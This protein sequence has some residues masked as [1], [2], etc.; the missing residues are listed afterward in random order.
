[1]TERRPQP[2]I[3]Y[4][5]IAA[6]L[7]TFAVELANGASP[8]TPS[9]AE[10][11]ALGGN[12][13]PLTL[14]GEWWRLGSSLFL[15]FG[16]L[17][18]ALNMICLYQVRTVELMF[19]RAGFAV[20]YAVSGLAG[21]IASLLVNPGNVVAA[22]AS[23][24]VFGVFGAYGAKLLLHRAQFDPEAWTKT[25][26]RLAQFLVLNAVVGLTVPGISISSHIGGLI[27][28][29]AA[30]AALLAGQR[31]EASRLARLVG[32]AVLGIV[33]TGVGVMAIDAPVDVMPVLRK[34]DALEQTRIATMT[35]AAEKLKSGALTRDQYLALV[36]REV[37][38][39]YR[40]LQQEMRALPEVPDRL[41]QL[42]ALT[43][44]L[45]TEHLALWEAFKAL[46]AETDPAKREALGEAHHRAAETVK[47]RLELLDA[48]IRRL[49]P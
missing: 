11:I 22:G 31:A 37:Y 16:V 24:C 14:H 12:Y 3:M 25:M 40:K 33:L 44:S 43:D 1:M 41:N 4:G 29:T 39:P 20:I 28:G 6:N 45:I 8:I 9:A 18:L 34:F 10:V 46:G 13:P 7:A 2:W 35:S 42:F 48:E 38:D 5:L 30:G 15:H 17:H 27:A 19:G 49:K 47:Q 32:L 26:R 36:E 21:G 23:G